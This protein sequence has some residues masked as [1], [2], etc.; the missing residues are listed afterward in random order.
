[1]Q[2]FHYD[3]MR[4][5]YGN[6]IKLLYTDTDSLCYEIETE[7]LY[8]D[9][10]EMRDHFDFHKYQPDHP[11]YSDANRMVV[12]K[13]KDENT[14]EDVIVEFV[15]VRT[16]MYSVITDSNKCKKKANGLKPDVV[17]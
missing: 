15:A 6:K 10:E 11:L 12:G 3:V 2:Q 4:A 17:A 9:L 7:D 8:A 16:K 5:R 1:M 13:F 14:P